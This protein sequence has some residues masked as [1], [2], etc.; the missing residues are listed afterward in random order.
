M[1]KSGKDD[2]QSPSLLHE[3]PHATV[4]AHVALVTAITNAKATAREITTR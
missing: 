2:G 1:R 3:A 4:V